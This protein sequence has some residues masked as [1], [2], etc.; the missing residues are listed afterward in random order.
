VRGTNL[1]PGASMLVS[2]LSIGLA[3]AAG[4]T[5]G[6]FIAAPLGTSMDRWQRRERWRARG[7]RT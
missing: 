4:V 1:V 2:A 7:S 6:E 5:L 3:L